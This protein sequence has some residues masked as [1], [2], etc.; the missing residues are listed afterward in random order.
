MIPIPI[1]LSSCRSHLPQLPVHASTQM[2][3]HNTESVKL[4][5]QY[6]V[7]RVVLLWEMS[8]E[9]IASLKRK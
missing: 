2:T 4:L 1:C 9:E 7:K 6:G 5:E 3:V 8:L